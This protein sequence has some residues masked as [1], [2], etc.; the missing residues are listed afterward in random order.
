MKE[1]FSHKLLKLMTNNYGALV[2]VMLLTIATAFASYD[3]I[4]AVS[5]T[6]LIGVFWA[7]IHAGFSAFS[8]NEK[9]NWKVR[10]VIYAVAVLLP[11]IGLIIFA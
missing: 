9:I 4:N 6:L 1:K 8:S 3:E 5:F 11:V 7:A 2:I 10:I